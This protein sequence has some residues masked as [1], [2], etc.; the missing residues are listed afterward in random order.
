MAL[1]DIPLTTLQGE[2]TSLAAFHGKAL[3]VVNVAS[4]CG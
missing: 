3:L 4:K 2:Q 1:P